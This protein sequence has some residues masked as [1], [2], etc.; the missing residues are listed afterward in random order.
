MTGVSPG[1]RA[2]LEILREVDQ[3]ALLDRALDRTLERVAPEERSWVHELTYGVVR[4]RGRLDH[5]LDH[6][7]HQ[8]VESVSPL[9]LDLLRMGAYQL[10]HMDG[11][12]A[13]AAVSQTVEHVRDAA[14]EGA[15][16]LANGVLRSVERAGEDPA[17]FPDPEDDPGGF[18]STWGSHP[19]WL[20]DRWLQRWTA[21]DV[22]R[23]VDHDNAVPRLTI[24]PVDSTPERAAELLAEAGLE[25]EAVGRETGCL[26][27]GR[28]TDPATALRR[29][30]ALVQ[31]PGAAL[32]VAYAAPEPGSL[33]ADLCAAPGGKGL[34]LAP[35]AAYL[36]AA[37]PSRE[38]LRRL[39]E[40]RARLAGALGSVGVVVARAEAPPLREA[41]MVLLDVPCTGTGTL[42]ARPDARWRLE[43]DD[44][45]ALA[46]LQRR[47]LEGAAE[48]VAP[49][50]LLVYSTCTLEPEE[51]EEQVRA[52]LDDFPDFRLDPGRGAPADLLDADGCLRVT[53]QE[54]GFDGA[55]AARIRRTA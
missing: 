2:A 20:V 15:A 53:P 48:V 4:L 30:P 25:A 1:R 29:V 39:Q 51:N 3:G 32:V 28:G 45:G 12:P 22:R 54:T 34:A 26:R 10:F 49:G 43:P 6:H 18:L 17:L 11:V 27:L 41:D 36:L 5:I 33:V 44:V 7:L 31:G 8:G 9:L 55:F 37:D 38:R 19:R 47:L 35:G 24:R 52:F 14:G 40:N 21:D 42:Q 50:G 46:R 23:L 16:R 13:Y